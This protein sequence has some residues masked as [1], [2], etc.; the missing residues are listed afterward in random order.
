MNDEI[1]PVGYRAHNPQGGWWEDNK[2]KYAWLIFLIIAVMFVMLSMTFESL[3]LPLAVIFMVPISFI[4][5][6]LAFGLS[7]L[8]FDQGG[9]A[10]FV[11]LCGIVVNA[12]IYIVLT[13][14]E[15]GYLKAFSLKITPIT[16]TIISTVLGLIPFL[17]DAPQEVFWF[18][19]A[20]GTISGMV[21]S[22]IAVILVLPV[23]VVRKGTPLK[24]S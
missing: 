1:L 4:G 11:M 5:V 23:F 19:F 18:D 14:K 3:R 17:T 10:A 20:I 21:F 6:F 9:F 16:L 2:D 13:Y 7:D 8:A 12:G 24:R 22:V 15:K